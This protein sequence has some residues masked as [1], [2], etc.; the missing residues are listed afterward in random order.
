MKL[1]RFILTSASYGLAEIAARATQA[2]AMF[3]AAA[4]CTKQTFGEI[5]LL[6]AVQQLITLFGVGGTVEAISGQMRAFRQ[7]GR[8]PNLFASTKWVSVIGCVLGISFYI[9]AASALGDMFE[10]KPGT[11]LEALVIVSGLWIAWLQLRANIQ[12]LQENH[13]AAI[14]IKTLPIFFM[15]IGAMIFLVWSPTPTGYLIGIVVGLALASVVVRV[16]HTSLI[17]DNGVASKDSVI[18]VVKDSFPYLVAALLAW[19]SGY[20]ANLF[21]NTEFPTTIVAEFAFVLSLNAILLLVANSINQ[22]WAPRFLQLGEVKDFAHLN[23]VN[24]VANRISLYMVAIVAALM[25][26]TFPQMISMSWGNLSQYQ[27]IHPYLLISFSTYIALTIYYRS[28][29]YFLLERA[30]AIFM[31]LT[32]WSTLFGLILWVGFIWLLGVWGIYVGLMVTTLLRGGIISLYAKRR[33]NI[34]LDWIDVFLALSF[35]LCSYLLAAEVDSIF[36]RISTVAFIF[37]TL[38]FFRLFHCRK[39]IDFAA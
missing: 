15:Y 11:M 13:R 28:V 18:M 36:I 14:L 37:L 12:R 6:I 30:G 23:R 39:Y 17:N 21:I 35:L 5:A 38:A 24:S 20:G 3:W 4:V 19:M 31:R 32:I 10:Y 25:L 8:L 7:E 9:V 34:S 29:N 33:W 27:N 22:V 2:V 1:R 26:S 16:A